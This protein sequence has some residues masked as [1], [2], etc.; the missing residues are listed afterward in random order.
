MVKV[1]EVSIQL[2]EIHKKEENIFNC[3][4]INLENNSSIE[5]YEFRKN[6]K[7]EN[8]QKERLKKLFLSEDEERTVHYLN[9]GLG[10]RN[11]KLMGEYFENGGLICATKYKSVAK[12]VRPVNQAMPQ[13]IN[14]P[15]QKPELSRDPYFC[16]LSRSP[17]DFTPS[18]K[19][20]WERL[21]MLSFAPEDWLTEEEIKLLL[22]VIKLRENAIAFCEEERGLL[23]RSWGLPYVIPVVEHVPWQKKTIPIPQAIRTEFINL[24]KEG[25]KTGLYEQSTSSYSS[26]VFCVSKQNGK[27]RI[28]HDLQE[29]NRVTI[30]DAGLPPAPEEFVENFAGRACYGL[31]DVFGGYDERELA[32]ESRPLTTFE[33]PVGRM[34]LTRLPQGATNSVSVYQAQ[35]V[36][37]IQDE[38]PENFGIFI[39]YSGIKGPNSTYNNEKL[40]ENSEIRRFIWVYAVALERVLFRLEAGL[41]I[42]ANNFAVCVPELE[43]VGHVVGMNG[44]TISEKKKNKIRAWPVPRNSTDVR[45]F[46]GVCVYFRI[47]I[48][49]FSLFSA[50]LRKLTRKDSEFIW[51]E[52]MQESFEK[53][54]EI[55]GRDILLKAI[56]Y[57]KEAGIIRLA[58]DSSSLAAGAVLTQEDENGL[59]RPVLYESIVFS[60]VESRYSQPKLELCGVAKI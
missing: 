28:V 45:G 52:K 58:V 2:K 42:S 1:T 60:E 44:R 27:I 56:D 48:E 22:Q 31:G 19:V 32:E 6:L 25:L 12:K 9:E 14:P 16:P 35:M 59:D 20:T 10:I 26:P 39:H 33:T 15:L 30:K 11:Q 57:S 53:L 23:K 5:I 21:E 36:W 24:V 37:V 49:N 50:P 41:T 7:E 54:K 40:E 13:N 43:I 38:I 3:F 4:N 17:P 18:K 47:F 29:L 55:V 34:Q 51:T 46:L 8:N